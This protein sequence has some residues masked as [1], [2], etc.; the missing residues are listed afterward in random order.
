MSANASKPVWIDV[1]TRKRRDQRT[2]IES[3]MTANLNS[4]PCDDEI[5]H[6]EYSAL[7]ERL[8]SGSLSAEAVTIAYIRGSVTSCATRIHAKIGTLTI[9]Q[10]GQSVHTKRFESSYFL[11]L[12]TTFL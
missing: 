11:S 7:V 1:V 8:S 9:A 3:F 10:T 4:T 5:R 6:L 12:A 2:A